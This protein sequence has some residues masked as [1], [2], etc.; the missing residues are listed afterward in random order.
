MTSRTH[1]IYKSQIADH[2]CLAQLERWADTA[3]DLLAEIGEVNS[4]RNEAY[5]AKMKMESAK[6]GGR[7]S[8]LGIGSSQQHRPGELQRMENKYKSLVQAF[9]E[10]K[11]EFLGR[12]K[13]FQAQQTN[14]QLQSVCRFLDNQW[15]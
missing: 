14:L 8:V 5:D 6:S 11:K 2:G 9:R 1:Q 13:E 10:K 4:V 7:T 12:A 15:E 3:T